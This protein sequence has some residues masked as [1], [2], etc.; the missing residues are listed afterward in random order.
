MKVR[1]ADG[2]GESDLKY[3]INDIDRHGNNRIY[4]RRPGGRK[5]RMLQPHEFRGKEL[6]AS[7]E[8]IAEHREYYLG[9]QPAPQ[10]QAP[11]RIT[12]SKTIEW[13]LRWIISKYYAESDDYADLD[14]RTKHVRKLILDEVCQE[15]FNDEDTTPVGDLDC[16]TMPPL[17]IRK[18]R[19]RKVDAGAP[20][21]GNSRLKALRQV[22]KYGVDKL[23]LNSNPARDVPYVK[24]G[25]DGFH[26][27]DISEVRKYEER[28]PIG[29]KE[30][31]ALAILLY[32]GPR[33][34]D[35][36]QFG[37]QHVRKP[38]HMSAAM[39][40][41]HPGRWLKF[42]QH[43][44]RKKKPVT[45]E[46]PILP[47]LEA[48]LEASTLGDMTWLVTEFKKPYTSNGFGNWFR[49]RCN[50]A[51]L[52]H[53]SAHG[54][55]KAGAVIAAENGATTHQLMAI[56]GWRTLKEAE[57]YTRAAQQKRLAGGAMKMLIPAKA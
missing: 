22:F 49:E 42:T 25:S 37:K 33:R 50:Q 9:K 38:E 51:G 3:L 40:E 24:T 20:E 29:T 57:R 35:A 2:S 1:H 52:H 47:E 17:F 45:L 28:H 13:S 12:R 55:R 53:C 31:L 11:Q 5:I 21:A 48:V 18:L 15:P 26:T 10:P 4:F 44:N 43:K 34:S 19:D 39:R 32:L 16:R 41:I 14:K 54:L 7:I 8:F 30:R 56:F 23:N 46:L 27:W 6:I 36:V